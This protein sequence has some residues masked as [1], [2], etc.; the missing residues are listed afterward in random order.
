MLVAA[1]NNF[2]DVLRFLIESGADLN[3]ADDVFIISKLQLN[4][5][6]LY[7]AAYHGYAECVELLVKHGIGI[8]SQN[9]VTNA[10]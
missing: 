8:D 5:A 2:V 7:T 9:K 4:L 3:F 6:A 1:K 10:Y